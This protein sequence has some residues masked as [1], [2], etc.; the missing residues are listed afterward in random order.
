MDSDSHTTSTRFNEG[1]LHCL[2][3]GLP[4]GVFL[5]DP[6]G[7]Y[8]CCGL[9][10]VESYDDVAGM[11]TLRG[12]VNDRS[13]EN[14]FSPLSIENVMQ[15]DIGTEIMGGAKFELERM[16]H[17]LERDGKLTSN[18]RTITM[19][20]EASARKFRNELLVEYD[21]KCAF[22]QCDIEPVLQAAHIAS[23]LGSASNRPSN[24]LLLRA[25]I[26]QL[27]SRHLI[28][29]DPAERIIHVAPRL[30]D[31]DYGSLSGRKLRAPK[32]REARPSEQR[33]AA[34]FAMF[35]KLNEL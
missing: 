11:F 9:A 15:N 1:L 31:S 8:L 13:P 7:E 3:D 17:E 22:S 10:F 27:F 28:A 20:R 26:R 35:S 12:P 33:L 34:H 19:I 4:V 30:M 6:S 23:R 32:T 14:E 2:E 25:D 29:V 18:E 5:K 21:G 16:Q 24:G